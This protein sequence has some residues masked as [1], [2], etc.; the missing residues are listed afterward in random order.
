M[1]AAPKDLVPTFIHSEPFMKFWRIFK[2]I[3]K[4]FEYDGDSHKEILKFN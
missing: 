4:S 1:I 3:I 2:L